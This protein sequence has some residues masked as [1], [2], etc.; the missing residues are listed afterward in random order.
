MMVGKYVD[1]QMQLLIL[2]NFSFEN[3]SHFYYFN[4]IQWSLHVVL[5]QQLLQF[6]KHLF[7]YFHFASAFPQLL[8]FCLTFPLPFNCLFIC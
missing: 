8:Q 5:F 2:F 6:V 3:I 7:P 4:R 1:P